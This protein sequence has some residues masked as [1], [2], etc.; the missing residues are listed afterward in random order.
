VLAT[1][2][3]RAAK[4]RRRLLRGTRLPAYVAVGVAITIAFNMTDIAVVAF[5]SGRHA[6]AG[7]G[8]VLAVWSL[9]SLV[10]GLWFGAGAARV[11][12]A[13]VVRATA[14]IAGGV[15]VAALAPG[16]IGLGMIMFAGGAAIA[17]GLARLYT[18]VGA[19]APEG[20][21]TEAFGWMAVGLLAGSSIGAALG[22][23]TVDALG[24]RACFLIAAAAPA[25]T[26]A[27]LFGWLHRR[28]SADLVEQ[29]LAS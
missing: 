27:G 13:A 25:L 24:A 15:A 10:G 5:V 22:G 16:N 9:G 1:P 23:I 28:R 8:V 3:I 12:D 11:D 4:V 17:P 21:A 29:P 7:A 19:V 18:R 14:L 26:A 20:A 2:A 6:S